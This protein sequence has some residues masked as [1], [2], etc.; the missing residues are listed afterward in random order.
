MHSL[1]TNGRVFVARI[2]ASQC[3]NPESRVLV[4]CL[5]YRRKRKAGECKR[6]ESKITE[7]RYSFHMIFSIVRASHS[8]TGYPA[9]SGSGGALWGDA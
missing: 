4:L 6:R 7:F 9:E 3:L 1:K 5:Q 2:V 8:L